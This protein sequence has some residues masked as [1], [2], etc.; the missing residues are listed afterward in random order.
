MKY[1]YSIIT[2]LLFAT[3]A[4]AARKHL[5][6]KENIHFFKGSWEQAVLEAKKE[7]KPLFVDVY[8]TWCGPCQMLK[9]I[10]FSNKEAAA[11]YNTSFINLSLNGEEREGTAIAARY[12]LKGYPSLLYFDKNG[13]LILY[14]AGYVGPAEFIQIAQEAFKRLQH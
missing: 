13:K 14:A 6:G 7:N 11:F 12:S 5:P 8:A 2:V 4:F 10:T 1:F 9:H 3:L